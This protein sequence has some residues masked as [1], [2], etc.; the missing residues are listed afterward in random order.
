MIWKLV[1]DA[2]GRSCC[3][4]QKVD[5]QAHKEGADTTTRLLWQKAT[6]QWKQAQHWIVSKWASPV[7]PAFLFWGGGNVWSVWHQQHA[8]GCGMGYCVCCSP[9]LVSP[10]MIWEKKLEPESKTGKHQ[11]HC[12]FCSTNP[13][14]S[15][16][17]KPQSQAPELQ[18]VW[19]AR[20]TC[21]YPSWSTVQIS[22]YVKTSIT[23]PAST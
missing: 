15:E 19:P 20:G 7:L 12:S 22:F 8:S 1:S 6:I 3:W 9:P 21:W 4:I 23:I 16:Q 5:G 13:K 2:S 17:R 10:Q 14:R 18:T 11:Y